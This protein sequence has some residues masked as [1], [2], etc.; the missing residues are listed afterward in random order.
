MKNE[1]KR[2]IRKTGKGKKKKSHVRRKGIFRKERG[3]A[4]ERLKRI[5]MEEKMLY[6]AELLV[7]VK[8]K[9]KLSYLESL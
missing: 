3:G 5:A 6:V 4:E 7:K 9:K 2:G 1:R 8:K